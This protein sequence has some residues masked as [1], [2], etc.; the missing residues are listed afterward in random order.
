MN[1]GFDEVPLAITEEDSTSS[2]QGRPH[3]GFVQQAFRLQP[4]ITEASDTPSAR[5]T[6]DLHRQLKRYRAEQLTHVFRMLSGAEC[7]FAFD[8]DMFNAYKVKKYTLTYDRL[9]TAIKECWPARFFPEQG[10]DVW[11]YPEGAATCPIV[12]EDAIKRIQSMFESFSLLIGDRQTFQQTCLEAIKEVRG[13]YHQ[14][15]DFN[16]QLSDSKSIIFRF[17]HKCCAHPQLE[18]RKKL[19]KLL[20]LGEYLTYPSY[21]KRDLI[22][23]NLSNRD[24]EY[25]QRGHFLTE[26]QIKHLSEE[27]QYFPEEKRSMIQAT[28][29]QMDAHEPVYTSSH[30][31]WGEGAANMVAYA[32]GHLLTTDGE[33]RVHI[34]AAGFRHASL[35]PVD[36]YKKDANKSQSRGRKKSQVEVELHAPAHEVMAITMRNVEQVLTAQAQQ[37][38]MPCITSMEP[39]ELLKLCDGFT[40]LTPLVI[41]WNNMQ[42][43]T[44]GQFI[45]ADHQRQQHEVTMLALNAFNES[46]LHITIQTGGKPIQ[47]WIQPK[48]HH[49][50]M[51]VN[52]FKSKVT[53]LQ[54]YENKMGFVDFY[55]FCLRTSKEMLA[56]M[57][58]YD[59]RHKPLLQLLQFMLQ[60]ESLI[61]TA[62]VEESN[63]PDFATK[64]LYLK[65]ATQAYRQSIEEDDGEIEEHKRKVQERCKALYEGKG[66]IIRN[67]KKYTDPTVKL[68]GLKK[69]KTP[70]YENTDALLN[71]I[72]SVEEITILSTK[73][74][75]DLS[76]D[77]CKKLPGIINK[78]I[79]GLFNQAK[80]YVQ[81]PALRG[82]TSHHNEL[83]YNMM[84][85]KFALTVLSGFA[86]KFKHL[87]TEGQ[88]SYI[89]SFTEHFYKT[90]TFELIDRLLS[91]AVN[92]I[93]AHKA[94]I[95]Q[96]VFADPQ[97]DEECLFKLVCAHQGLNKMVA[98]FNED[99]WHKN[100]HN[101]EF[102]ARYLAI[103]SYLDAT[104][105]CNCKSCSDRAGATH[106]H[107]KT[108][109]DSWRCCE[110]P[111][112]SKQPLE[113]SEYGHRS[114][115][116]Y[117]KSA[118]QRNTAYDLRG[119]EGMKFSG[120]G[121]DHMGEP[122]K[123]FS[124]TSKLAPHKMYKD[125]GILKPQKGDRLSRR[126]IR[127]DSSAPPVLVLKSHDD[128]ASG[129]DNH[130]TSSHDSGLF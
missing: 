41:E 128:D 48:V 106:V 21:A 59:G 117:A 53:D 20:E 84:K 87:L 35:P 105:S 71:I 86:K 101:F 116:V 5:V 79:L 26:A 49:M 104:A 112:R 34:D 95:Y 36:L 103:T 90:N 4:T 27:G 61:M 92:H 22:V 24:V 65:I 99:N 75:S 7:P 3:L 54:H 2:D 50:C 42:V 28:N 77:D 19:P 93:K 109:E 127:A 110:F 111:S 47:L 118:G 11:L 23:I 62:L 15:R 9:P 37:L 88:L 52:A 113:V 70:K 78:L 25:Y 33:P 58:Q 44:P 38:L 114:K 51:G 123:Q 82:D 55:K 130:S 45:S 120:P 119:G 107:K 115:E 6:R 121:V 91:L 72:L 74:K 89:N 67:F 102:Q 31:R 63:Y 76:V 69:P 8:E 16:Q 66:K 40:Q 17:Y 13:L 43:F 30:R 39:A 80:R 14:D 129:E 85:M 73:Q 32:T 68:M 46:E 64:K 81:S 18:Q 83:F 96:C 100:E 57:D 10:I 126:G 29:E 124:K 108:L 12:E 122:K 60:I 56:R 97:P 98:L 1:D 125:D 94:E